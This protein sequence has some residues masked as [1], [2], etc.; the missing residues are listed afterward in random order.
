MF[1]KLL[2]SFVLMSFSL[3]T[4]TSVFGLPQRPLRD[5]PSR[6]L[7]RY[8]Y[9]DDLAQEAIIEIHDRMNMVA[10]KGIDEDRELVTALMETLDS[11]NVQVKVEAVITLS[12]ARDN[13]VRKR[14]LR[15]LGSERDNRVR[16]AVVA[17]VARISGGW[18]TDERDIEN[19]KSIVLEGSESI[20]GDSWLKGNAIYALG[21]VGA[22]T[23]LKELR[24]HEGIRRAYGHV[25][26]NALERAREVKE[27]APDQ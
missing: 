5:V 2:T 4:L 17:S 20:D 27:K 16:T 12:L 15:L 14:I 10:V 11:K 8:L 3:L 1:Q 6:E 19:I 7:V 18:P 22:I 25:I 23:A 9:T 21:A 26:D 24:Q 13:M